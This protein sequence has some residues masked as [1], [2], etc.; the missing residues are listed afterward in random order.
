MLFKKLVIIATFFLTNNG[1]A[2]NNTQLPINWY[3]LD[4]QWDGYYGISLSD[5]YKVVEGKPSK[6]IIV[7]II[8]DGVDTTNEFIKNKLWR[9]GKEIPGNGIDDDRNGYVDDI[10]GWN[11]YGVTGDN[12]KRNEDGTIYDIPF[13]TGNVTAKRRCLLGTYQAGIV[14]RFSK[15]GLDVGVA[16]NVNIMTLRV[17]EPYNNEENRRKLIRGIKYA[18]DNRAKIILLPLYIRDETNWDDL[19]SALIW[20]QKKGAL[21]IQ[22]AGAG[23]LNM[24]R[25]HDKYFFVKG[26]GAI[27]VGSN[28]AR[29]PLSISS[30]YG[31]TIVDLFAPGDSIYST[32]PKDWEGNKD[33]FGM[34]F[35]NPSTPGS[36]AIVAGIAAF[37]LSYYPSLTPWQLKNIL[38][39]SV[40]KPI[41]DAYVPSRKAKV[42]L[43]ELCRSGG[44]INALS[45]IK[46]AEKASRSQRNPVSAK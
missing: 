8:G 2:Q 41:E 31:K 32:L 23:S 25:L 14:S 21:I 27:K 17:I 29:S 43:T 5:A 35:S 16:R 19:D 7:A 1:K 9:N 30:S 45:A 12:E 24:D 36:A 13:E 4:K 3:M 42:T 38:D 44:I 6:N 22:Q 20:A 39:S 46:L 28:C 10:Y 40:L 11:Y 37:V 15:D 26:N 34:I 33:G 18:V